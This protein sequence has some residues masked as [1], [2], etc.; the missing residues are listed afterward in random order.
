MARDCWAYQAMKMMK[1]L[2]ISRETSSVFLANLDLVL[3]KA[4]SFGF[5][6]RNPNASVWMLLAMTFDRE[7]EAELTISTEGL[8]RRIH[9]RA[10]ILAIDVLVQER[11]VELLLMVRNADVGDHGSCRSG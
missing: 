2:D 5:L 7:I 10:C 11:A 1:T 8:P 6:G 4:R 3:C 9:L